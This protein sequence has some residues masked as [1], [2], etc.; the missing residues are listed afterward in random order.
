MPQ[1]PKINKIDE[2]NN[3]NDS[4]EKINNNKENK[5]KIIN[6]RNDNRKN[7]FNHINNNTNININLKAKNNA[8][9]L[10]YTKS[11]T[12]LN[13][14]KNSKPRKQPSCIL[15]TDFYQTAHITNNNSFKKIHS[16]ISNLKNS[17][18]TIEKVTQNKYKNISKNS[19]H[20]NY[21]V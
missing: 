19:S 4:F 15:K 17:I 18:N 5:L 9:N 6:S 1:K 12:S 3:K 14:F 16:S 21:N 11:N 10:R 20:K 2:K 8:M 7:N 13:T